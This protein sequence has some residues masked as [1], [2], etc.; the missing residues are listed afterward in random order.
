M[1]VTPSLQKFLRVQYNANKQ[2]A[3]GSFMSH[4][5]HARNT[6]Y[7]E[8]KYLTYDPPYALPWQI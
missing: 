5:Q 1:S 6:L 2:N 3:F 7:N 8:A 4:Y